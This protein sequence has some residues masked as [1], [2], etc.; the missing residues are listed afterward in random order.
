MMNTK[1]WIFSRPGGAAGGGAFCVGAR[2]T[3]NSA[4]RSSG[5]RARPARRLVVR[6]MTLE[7]N[8]DD[9]GSCGWFG[10]CR[11][12]APEGGFVGVAMKIL[13]GWTGREACPT[14]A[15]LAA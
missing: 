1:C 13:F 7:Q 3:I 5:N 11:N 10:R 12:F 15:L 4:I 14:L 9:A 6:S 2:P 8:R